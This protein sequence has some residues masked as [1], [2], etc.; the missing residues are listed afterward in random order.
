MRE[1]QDLDRDGQTS[2]QSDHDDE[3]DA[4]GLRVDG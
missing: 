1:E 2:V 4:R 3:Q